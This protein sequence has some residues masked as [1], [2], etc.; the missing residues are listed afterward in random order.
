MLKNHGER[1]DRLP[2]CVDL[3]GTLISEDVTLWSIKNYVLKNPFNFFKAFFW[4][5]SGRANVK[6]QIALRIESEFDASEFTYNKKLLTFIAEKKSEGHKIFLATAS[7]EI[8]ANKVADFL[9]IFDGIFA[10]NPAVNLRAEAKADALATI[11]GEKGFIYAGNSIYDVPV[12]RRSAESI[13][14]NPTPDALK[15]MKDQEYILMES[16]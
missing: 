14:V 12:W 6:R 15:M 3:D 8:L 5:L 2:V 16:K 9:N 1:M 4:L 13:L 11:F 10:S 7:D